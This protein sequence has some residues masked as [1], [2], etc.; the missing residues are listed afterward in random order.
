V[1][2]ELDE[3]VELKGDL[4]FLT[5]REREVAELVSQGMTNQQAA[6]RLY[7]SEK[8]VEFHLRNVYSKLGIS[9][10]RELRGRG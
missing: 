3:K 9:S 1:L 2:R 10:R 5:A 4:T 7:L 8:T 6:S